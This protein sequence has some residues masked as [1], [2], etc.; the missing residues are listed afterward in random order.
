[1][2]P[3]LKVLLV[4]LLVAIPALPLGQ[5][6]W[7]APAEMST[8]EGGMPAYVPFLIVISVFEALSLG[9]G[10]AFLAF[11]LPLV[12]RIGVWST[13][14]SWAVFLSIAWFLVSW[15]PHDGFHR[16]MGVN[17]WGLVAVE[18]AFHVTL[19]SAGAIL[20]LAFVRLVQQS[21]TPARTV[22]AAPRAGLADAAR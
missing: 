18:Y 6:L 5:V 19:M 9:L 3:W 15:W 22:P 13:G 12:R 14:M 1:M 20:A 7:P 16:S 2:K 4:T 21:V 17:M 10:I 11:G 8:G